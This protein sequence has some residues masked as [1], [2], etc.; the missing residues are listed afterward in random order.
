MEELVIFGMMEKNQAE[1]DQQNYPHN[2]VESEIVHNNLLTAAIGNDK[3]ADN[4]SQADYNVGDKEIVHKFDLG[5]N[6]RPSDRASIAKR[7][8]E[9]KVSRLKSLPEMPGAKMETKV[10]PTSSFDK[11]IKYSEVFSNW[12]SVNFISNN[13][14]SKKNRRASSRRQI[15]LLT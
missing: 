4:E 9:E 3:I 6:L 11:S 14:Y 2:N 5:N 13:N 1:K 7:I 8:P 15:S 12:D 10:E